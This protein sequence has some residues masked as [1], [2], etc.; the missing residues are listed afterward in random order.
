LAAL[1]LLAA[2]NYVNYFGK[3]TQIDDISIRPLLF[4][5]GDTKVRN[6]C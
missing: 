1:D 4:Q 2:S 5:K 6:P 3:N